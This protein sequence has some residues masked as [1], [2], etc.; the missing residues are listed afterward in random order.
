MDNG[1]PKFFSDHTIQTR[2]G[3][4]D[5]VSHPPCEMHPFVRGC[6][7]WDFMSV[8]QASH[9]PQ[10]TVLDMPLQIGKFQPVPRISIY[11]FQG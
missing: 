11:F 8:D 1:K 5:P 9:K 4:M 6:A 10:K 3:V 2:H 7:E